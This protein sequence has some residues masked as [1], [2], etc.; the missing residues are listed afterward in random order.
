MKKIFVLM[1]ALCLAEVSFAQLQGGIKAG[2]NLA[3]F[4]GDDADGSKVRLGY[5]VGGYLTFDVSDALSI[6][7]E[8]L[9]NSLGSKTK[10]SGS[11]PDLGDYTIEGEIIVTYVTV[12]VMFVFRLNDQI[13]IQAGP[14]LGILIAGKAKY[15]ITSDLITTSGSE[16]VKDQ[17]KSTDFGLSAGLGANFGP[18]T[19]SL[20]YYLGLADI[21][22]ADA[23]VKNSA[24]ML[25]LGYNISKK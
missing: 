22:D 6:Q 25:S 24:F 9:I 17:F 3:N 8:L 21:P 11:D 18:V 19:T 14:Q 1:L 12:P 5:H 4:T 15:D 20:R 7:P 13:N 10:E 16:D 23:S 2:L